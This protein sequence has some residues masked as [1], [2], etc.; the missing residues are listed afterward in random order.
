[1]SRRFSRALAALVPLFVSSIVVACA[2]PTDDEV[3]GESEDAIVA[4][5]TPTERQAVEA[6]DISNLT[7]DDITPTG[8]HL[9]KGMVYWRQHQI[10]D[11]RYPVSRMCASNVSKAL[12]L[13]GVKNYNA[14]GVYEL[15]R[16]VNVQKGEIHRLPQPKKLAN[17]KLDKTKFLAELN[18]IDHGHL[19]VGTIV[20]GCLTAQCDAMPGEQHVGMIGD[21]DAN[22]TVWV[23]HNN[24][25]RPENEAPGSTSWK[26]YMIYGENHALYIEKGLRRQWMKT[27][28]LVIKKDANGQIID[29]VDNLPA[30]DDLDP[31]GGGTDPK[32]FMTLSVIPEIAAELHAR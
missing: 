12:F 16:S 31:F 30:I 13:G 7:F 5:V 24:W 32:Y 14:E 29:A 17:G 27:P 28:W 19:P 18:A 11:L 23:W 15:I 2:A 21:V 1:M 6:T 3:S 25:Y 4:T 26:P 22:G 9:M 20:A 8:T 10:E